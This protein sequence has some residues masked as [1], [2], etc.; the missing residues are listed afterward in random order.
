MPILVTSIVVCEGLRVPNVLSSPTSAYAVSGS[1]SCNL[2]VRNP[3][4]AIQDFVQRFRIAFK[5]FCPQLAKRFA[6]RPDA[7]KSV[8]LSFPNLPPSIPAATSDNH[9]TA[10]AT[11]LEQNPKQDVG[12]ILHESEHVMQFT[13][14]DFFNAAPGWFAEGLADYVRS[15]YGPK[16]D[17]WFMPEVNSTDS[18]KDAYRVTARFL[19][20]LEQH[21]VPD[22]V[23]QLNRAMLQ[24]KSFSATF[25]RLAGNT[26]DALWSQYEANSAIKPFKHIFTPNTLKNPRPVKPASKVPPPR[27]SKV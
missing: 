26:V 2:I 16:D 17:D 21:T 24:G 27:P 19:H 25:K 5:T 14:P 6:I 15:I 12:A 13:S 22:I 9:I 20:W 7:V 8:V 4:S 10:N 3:P 1:A 23:D 11:W 18:Y